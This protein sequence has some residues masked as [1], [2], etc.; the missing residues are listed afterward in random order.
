MF[1]CQEKVLHSRQIH[2]HDTNVSDGNSNKCNN[3]KHCV[4]ADELFLPLVDLLMV[5]LSDRNCIKD[6]FNQSS[7]SC[8][9]RVRR[10]IV[11]TVHN[12]LITSKHV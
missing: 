5:T 3:H 8:N 10:M 12:S 9:A 1:T 2:P 4:E 7:H 11:S 6:V